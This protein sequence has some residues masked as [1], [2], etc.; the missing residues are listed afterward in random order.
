MRV[1]ATR[2]LR[3]KHWHISTR[4]GDQPTRVTASLR[5]GDLAQQPR[6]NLELP[7]SYPLVHVYLGTWGINS[8]PGDPETVLS[9]LG[10]DISEDAASSRTL[11]SMTS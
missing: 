5:T 3:L 11:V 6:L 9:T 10:A 7:H 2:T 1:A 8:S 4:F